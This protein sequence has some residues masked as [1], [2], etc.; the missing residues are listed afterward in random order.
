[1]RQTT[2][3]GAD[4]G[5]SGGVAIIYPNNTVAAYAMPETERDLLDLLRG[6]WQASE[7]HLCAAVEAVHSMP[8]QGV[9]SS[10]KFGM[11]YGGL[12]MAVIASGIPLRSVTPQAW[13]KELQCLTKGDKL[14]SLRRAQ[15]LFPSFDWPKTKSAK[16]CIADAMLIAEW[17]RRT[18]NRSAL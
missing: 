1:M 17:L 2:Y 7:G 15:E 18:E 5:Q 16:L 12:R 11:G 3:I 14:V 10:F 9:A 6:E 4:P 8:R 13:Q